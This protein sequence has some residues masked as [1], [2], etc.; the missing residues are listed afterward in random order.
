MKQYTIKSTEDINLFFRDIH[1]MYPF[2]WHPDDDFH[3]FVKEDGETKAFTDEE[4]EYLNKVMIESF[5][6]CDNNDVDVY[7][8]AEQVQLELWKAQ[9]KW[10]LNK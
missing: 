1:E 5:D 8:I 10:P 9:G 2:E 3:F 7:E 6:Y 4:A